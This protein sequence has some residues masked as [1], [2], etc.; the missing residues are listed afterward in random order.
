MEELHKPL[1]VKAGHDGRDNLA[2]EEFR[3]IVVEQDGGKVFLEGRPTAIEIDQLVGV[4]GAQPGGRRLRLAFRRRSES[5]GRESVSA[6]GPQL[7]E[8]AQLE[9]EICDPAAI[10][11]ADRCCELV[12]SLVNAHPGLYTT[13][14]PEQTKNV[15]P[16][17]STS[18]RERV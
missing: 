13:A 1:V 3:A 6:R 12:E 7:D 11:A 14:P 4:G 5:V 18:S 2:A 16:A 8:I 15:L 10:E 17:G 9:P